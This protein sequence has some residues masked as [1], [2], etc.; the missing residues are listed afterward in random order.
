M[1]FALKR[2]NLLKQLP[3]RNEIILRPAQIVNVINSIS[4]IEYTAIGEPNKSEHIFGN[5]Y[6]TIVDLKSK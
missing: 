4:L 3:D 6:R 2:S 5:R 1:L